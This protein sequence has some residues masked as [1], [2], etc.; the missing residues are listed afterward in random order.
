MRCIEPS[1]QTDSSTRDAVDG[2]N[3]IDWLTCLVH[4]QSGLDYLSL[5]PVR[6]LS[7]PSNRFLFPLCSSPAILSAMHRII[8]IAELNP[9]LRPRAT[10][11]LLPR[12]GTSCRSKS[13]VLRSPT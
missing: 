10:S 2:T 3:T 9:L 6:R 13:R 8:Q 4:L 12:A 1:T 7:N 5:N 11:P